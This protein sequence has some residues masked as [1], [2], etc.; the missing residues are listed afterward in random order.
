MESL[1]SKGSQVSLGGGRLNPDPQLVIHGYIS[2]S[3]EHNLR[4][5]S[6]SQERAQTWPQPGLETVALGKPPG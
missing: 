3:G 2:I 6:G 1:A 4:M 5:C